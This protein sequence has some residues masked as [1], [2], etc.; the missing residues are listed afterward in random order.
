MAN[1]KYSQNNFARLNKSH[2]YIDPV[3]SFPKCDKVDIFSRIPSGSSR[4]F[5]DRSSMRQPPRRLKVIELSIAT[6]QQETLLIRAESSMDGKYGRTLGNRAL[7]CCGIVPILFQQC[8]SKIVVAI[9]ST[10]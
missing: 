3:Y 7:Q 4:C 6:I 2:D 1:V 9:R 8:C 10:F 5:I